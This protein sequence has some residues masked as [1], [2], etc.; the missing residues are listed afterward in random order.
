M[1]KPFEFRF[2]AY[3]GRVRWPTILVALILVLVITVV[4]FGA[5]LILALLMLVAAAIHYLFPSLR[6][7]QRRQQGV[8]QSVIID[9]EYRILEPREGDSKSTWDDPPRIA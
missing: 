7:S 6:R 8:K 5:A 2:R 3:S 9:G 1:P 4:A